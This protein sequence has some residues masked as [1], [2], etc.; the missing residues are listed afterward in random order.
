M[1]NKTCDWIHQGEGEFI[2]QCRN[3][4]QFGGLYSP[5][6]LEEDDFQILKF[7]YCPYCGKQI[8]VIQQTLCGSEPDGS[9]PKP[10]AQASHS[11]ERCTKWH[12]GWR[13]EL[14][15]ITP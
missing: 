1:D 14:H 15:P 5:F 3:E 10:V 12:F 7:V 13:K 6:E 4:H 9:T 11:G 8:N 2:T